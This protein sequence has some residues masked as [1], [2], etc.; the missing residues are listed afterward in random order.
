[1]EIKLHILSELSQ[2]LLEG[3]PPNHFKPIR[4]LPHIHKALNKYLKQSSHLL[5][6]T[7]HNYM[8]ILSGTYNPSSIQ[9][10]LT[11]LTTEAQDYETKKRQE[12][13][14]KSTLEQFMEY[15][16][17][18]I[19]ET[20]DELCEGPLN[21]EKRETH[22]NI[23][24]F[25]KDTKKRVIDNRGLEFVTAPSPKRRTASKITNS[26]PSSISGYA[27]AISK[28]FHS[29]LNRSPFSL[30]K[31]LRDLEIHRLDQERESFDMVWRLLDA[32]FSEISSKEPEEVI[33]VILRNTT[34]FFEQLFIERVNEVSYSSNKAF[35][36]FNSISFYC[37]EL[38]KRNS[39]S[40]IETDA[41]GEPCWVVAYLL[42]RAGYYQEL[43]N[44]ARS[45]RFLGDLSRYFTDYLENY[46]CVTEHCL[47][48]ILSELS[49][50]S[51]LD[52]FKRALFILLARIN[53]EIDELQEL[54]LEDYL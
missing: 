40:H 15:K 10:S 49:A 43:M 8:D 42:F 19:C 2:G 21:R 52:T 45:H 25:W 33:P 48:Q 5:S 38:L 14:P 22:E 13:R 36:A 4:R 32:Q 7:E 11:K 17:E 53:A 26:L 12:Q 34:N 23:T 51:V 27:A 29:K 9:L 3:I 24:V 18:F 44:Y 6:A 39:F 37:D 35:S 20:L 30:C 41:N 31:E 46:S 16:R 47:H 28:L 1:M 54:S 50:S